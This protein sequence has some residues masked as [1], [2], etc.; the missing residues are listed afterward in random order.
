[1]IDKISYNLTQQRVSI[2]KIET[3]FNFVCHNKIKTV[4][5]IA[6]IN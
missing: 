6:F 5:N 1:M 4:C 2:Q 3:L